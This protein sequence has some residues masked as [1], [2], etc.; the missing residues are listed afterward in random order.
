MW[1]GGGGGGCRVGKRINPAGPSPEKVVLD[2]RWV[3]ALSCLNALLPWLTAFATMAL[4]LRQRRRAGGG[5]GGGHPLDGAA[6]DRVQVLARHL[7]E[8]NLDGEAAV[9]PPSLQ[10][11]GDHSFAQ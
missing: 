2:Y 6:V 1:C 9:V 3:V 4:L 8:L 5:G 10:G 7:A 11:N